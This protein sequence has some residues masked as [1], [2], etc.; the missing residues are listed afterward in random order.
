MHGQGQFV[1]GGRFMQHEF[2]QVVTQA[3]TCDPL[4]APNTGMFTA[5]PEAWRCVKVDGYAIND[6]LCQITV[7]PL[8]VIRPA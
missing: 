8:V 4:V 7:T 3:V 2:S 1:D 5:W 6:W